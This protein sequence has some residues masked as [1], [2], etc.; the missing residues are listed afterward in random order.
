M[1]LAFT[2]TEIC[3]PVELY[4]IVYDVIPPCGNSGSDQVSKTAVELTTVALKLIGGSPGTKD[5]R[6]IL[7]CLKITKWIN[8][9]Y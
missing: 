1:S 2:V 8:N 3:L 6:K 7:G 4:A 9:S 5:Q